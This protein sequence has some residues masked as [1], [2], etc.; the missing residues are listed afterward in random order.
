MN[1]SILITGST[2]GIGKLAAMKMAKD[3]HHVFLH[4]RNAE[5][6]KT[7]IE[8]V[9]QATQNANID[10]FVADFSDMTQVKSM[11]DAIN[12]TVPHLDILINN[13]GIFKSSNPITNDGIDIRIAVNY[14]APYLLTH[15]I[16]DKLKTS[17]EPRIINLSSAAQSTVSLELLNGDLTLPDQEAYAQSKLAILMWSFH[18]ANQESSIAVNALNPGS[19]LNTNM[20]REAYGKFWS[21]ADKGSNIIYDLALVTSTEAMDGKYFDNDRGSFGPAHPDAYDT[22]MINTLMEHTESIVSRM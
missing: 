9:K 13:A 14:Y 2:D 15:N 5:K 17:N 1:K 20:V 22:P 10:G 3:G 6:L 21:P 12:A 8:E 11:S 4:G 18:L 16:I 19:L 7:V